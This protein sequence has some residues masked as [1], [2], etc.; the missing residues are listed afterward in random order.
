MCI[1]LVLYLWAKKKVNV[2]KMTRLTPE[3]V[4]ELFCPTLISCENPNVNGAVEKILEQNVWQKN[5]KKVYDFVFNVWGSTLNCKFLTG[6]FVGCKTFA[7]DCSSLE[8][9][10]EILKTSR[11]KALA[12]LCRDVLR[13]FNGFLS[14]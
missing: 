9:F 2:S 3:L 7:F 6:F 13:I 10:F 12:F 1:F 4:T 11:H 8:I 14:G 5:T